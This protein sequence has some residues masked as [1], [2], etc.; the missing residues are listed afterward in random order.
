MLKLA[1]EVAT[2]KATNQRTSLIK[3]KHELT[4]RSNKRKQVS[5]G[6]HFTEN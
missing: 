6:A 1:S 2:L 3:F 4:I 5:K